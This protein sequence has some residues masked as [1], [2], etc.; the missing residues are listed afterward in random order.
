MAK[1]DNILEE[2]LHNIKLDRNAANTALDEICQDIHTGKLDHGRSGMVVA[3]YLETLQRSNEQ[4]VKVASLMAKT[5]KESLTIS[6]E[7]IDAIYD[8]LDSCQEEDPGE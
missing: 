8:N 2:A 1:F 6:G 3:K 5:N 4:L 7:E